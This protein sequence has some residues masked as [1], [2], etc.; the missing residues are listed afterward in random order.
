MFLGQ[1]NKLSREEEKNQPALDF[2]AAAEVTGM[3]D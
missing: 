1:K 2:N 3:E